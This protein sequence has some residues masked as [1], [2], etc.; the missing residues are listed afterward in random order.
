MANPTFVENKIYHIY[1]RGVEKRKIFMDDK[2]YFR[3]IHDLFEFNDQN[4]V[5]NINYYFDTKTMSVESRHL[6]KQKA[7]KRSRKLLVE[8]LAFT[9]MPNHF[10]LLLRQRVEGGISKFA[11]KLGAGYAKYFNTR[12]ERVGSLFQGKFKAVSIDEDAHFL[13]ILHYIHS[14]PL[15]LSSYRPP[16]SIAREMKFLEDYRWSSY[17]DYIGKENFP[18][19]TQREFLLDFY[20][21]PEK[22][23]KETKEWIKDW[24]KNTEKVKE[25]SFD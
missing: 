22:Y 19:V 21:G 11:Q 25:V 3:F 13:H 9:L 16:R 6:K 8:I 15:S 14:N 2:D 23:K 17:M 12:Y 10:H 18:S 5:P 7:E 1:N 24:S 20:G 4:N